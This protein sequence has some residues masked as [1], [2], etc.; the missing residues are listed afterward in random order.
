MSQEPVAS[1]EISGR[2]DPFRLL[3]AEERRRH[4]SAYRSHLEARNGEIDLQGRRLSRREA[5]MD[6]LASRP[7]VAKRDLVD[8]AGLLEHMDGP[9]ATPIDEPTAWLVAVAKANEGE[10][11]G[12]NL[13]L[14]RFT[15]SRHFVRG[16]Q[17]IAD[18]DEGAELVQLYVFLEE[19][20]HSRILGEVCKVC[21]F[22]L[23]IREPPWRIRLLNRAIHYLPDRVRWTLILCGE[24][25]GVTVFKLFLDRCGL[26][27][28][29][30]EVAHR[31]RSLLG[32]IWRDELLH[33]ALL[34]ARLGPVSLR[35]AH[36]MLPFVVDSLIRDVPEL[37]LLGAS[38][39]EFMRRVRAGIEIPGE[40]DWLE[41]DR[42]RK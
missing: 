22:D 26:F 42:V 31:L 27:D 13:E 1:A 11:Y 39:D 20:Y 24:I 21:R 8:H 5:F 29:E 3:G 17:A 14:A 28:D 9:G 7:L 33:I 6:D 38:R 15:R 2:F 19:L 4:L 35:A 37:R 41:P 36:R 23:E 10:A 25:V 40:I 34:R 18:D 32:A 30:P 16:E 12:V